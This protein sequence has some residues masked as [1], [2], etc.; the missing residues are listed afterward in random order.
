MG[1]EEVGGAGR[2]IAIAACLFI[3]GLIRLADCMMKMK[4]TMKWMTNLPVITNCLTII[5]TPKDGQVTMKWR[6]KPRVLLKSVTRGITSTFGEM[7]MKTFTTKKL[8]GVGPAAPG[9]CRAKAPVGRAKALT[10]HLVNGGFNLNSRV[11][12]SATE[13]ERS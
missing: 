7:N 5:I 4:W 9:L 6:T 8:G 12:I 11:L 13:N 1:D 2:C 3:D 10:P